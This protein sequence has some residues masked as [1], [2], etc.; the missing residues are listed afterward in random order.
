ML[1]AVLSLDLLHSADDVSVIEL[2]RVPSSQDVE[3]LLEEP[4]VE[5]LH[6]L[7]LGLEPL[8]VGHVGRV[9]VVRLQAPSVALV[10]DCRV[11]RDQVDRIVRLFWVRELLIYEA[12][13]V[14]LA[15]LVL[16]DV[17]DL[18]LSRLAGVLELVES[19]RLFVAVLDQSQLHL[20]VE[21]VAA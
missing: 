9:S 20:F 3:L 15:P 8:V 18:P 7:D 2:L 6:H 12:A 14:V 17:P 13:V 10:G 11:D 16:D 5:V 21:V 4:Y 19:H 1:D